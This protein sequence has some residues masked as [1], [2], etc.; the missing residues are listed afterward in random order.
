[1]TLTIRKAQ[2][3][4]VVICTKTENIRN[5]HAVIFANI[6]TEPLLPEDILMLMVF[7]SLNILNI[8]K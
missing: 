2:L 8:M 5:V 4:K 6:L 3:T 7:N 1:M